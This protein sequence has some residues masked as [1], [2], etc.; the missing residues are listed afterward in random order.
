MRLTYYVLM[1]KRT[2]PRKRDTDEFI[3]GLPTSGVHRKAMINA[4][5]QQAVDDA[6]QPPLKR[7]A[8][9]MTRHPGLADLVADAKAAIAAQGGDSDE[10]V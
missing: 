1:S 7:L 9:K 5:A 6:L 10:P 8:K 3:V 4:G 2:T